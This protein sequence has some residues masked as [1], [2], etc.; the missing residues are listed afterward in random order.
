MKDVVTKQELIADLRNLGLNGGHSVLV[1]SSLSSLGYM[2]S[3]S[4]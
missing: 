4:Q 2:I 3:S 1:H